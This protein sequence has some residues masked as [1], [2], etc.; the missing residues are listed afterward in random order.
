[1]ELFPAV[2]PCRRRR[3]GEGPMER[4]AAE[5]RLACASLG[6]KDEH[7]LQSYFIARMEKFLSGKGR[8]L[9]GWDEILEGGLAPNATVM[10]WRGIDGAVA[11]AT[12]GHDAVLSP[13][14]TLYFDNRPVDVPS[15]RVVG[16]SSA[17]EEVYGFDPMPAAL[18]ES[19]NASTFW[20][21]RRIS[22]RNTCA[23]PG[24]RR[25]HDVP[26][27]GGGCRNRA[28]RPRTR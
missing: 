16:A 9:I 15:R 27:R 28:G 26:A 10:S 20:A 19:S 2:H 21:C 18:N 4:V 24:S 11:A 3:S 22:G 25:V 12:R 5:C 13:W 23:S 17:L 1:M 6:V 8:R 7:E 14:P